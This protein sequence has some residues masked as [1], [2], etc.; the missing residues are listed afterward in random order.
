MESD[1]HMEAMLMLVAT[2]DG[3]IVQ[4]GTAVYVN[5]LIQ[6][7]DVSDSLVDHQGWF[8]IQG[9][10]FPDLPNAPDVEFLRGNFTLE[11]AAQL[12]LVYFDGKQQSNM[13]V[14]FTQHI[15]EYSAND[16]AVLLNWVLP[17]LLAG[18]HNALVALTIY[19]AGGSR[20]APLISDLEA[21]GLKMTQL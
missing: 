6:P 9:Q 17:S 7:E 13:V 4:E 1:N 11:Y 5:E 20:I 14:L 19:G 15:I 3:Y 12:Y 2:P 18:E 10:D 8:T 21:A 16:I